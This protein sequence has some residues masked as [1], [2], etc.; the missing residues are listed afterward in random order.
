VPDTLGTEKLPKYV[1]SPSQLTDGY[2][3]QLAKTNGAKLATLD[4]GIPGA[5]RI[6]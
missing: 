1:R 4:A 3:L 5:L 6:G 2:I